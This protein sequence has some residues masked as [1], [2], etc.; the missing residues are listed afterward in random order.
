[1]NR[2]QIFIDGGN[3][4]NLAL[5]RINCHEVNFD[6][7]K[8]IDF[9]VGDRELI[10]P[11]KRFYIGTVRGQEDSHE[12]T[13]AMSNQTKLFR[14]LESSGWTIKTSKLRART[15]TITI[16]DRFKDYQTL[17]A[18]GVS[19]ITYQRSRE[20][21]IDV[22]LATDLLVGALDDKYD[23]AVVVSSDSDLVP[24]IDIVRKKFN[25]KIEYVSFS[26]PQLPELNI[27]ED[28]KPTK[29]MIYRSDIQRIIPVTD[30]NRFKLL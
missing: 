22:K 20:K 6:F 26:A 27:Y 1:M 11:G 16:D 21:G 10:Y 13:K 28:L 4:Y 17:L 14:K 15:E 3:F 8:F 24:A 19:E 25:K 7:D 30:L 18:N 5:K 23:I 29:V 9:L 12:T 2:V